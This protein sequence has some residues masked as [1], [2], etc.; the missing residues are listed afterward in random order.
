MA[1]MTAMRWR[2]LCLVSLAANLGLA[3]GWWLSLRHARPPGPVETVLSDTNASPQIR[4]NVVFRRQF[5]SWSELESPDY[6]KYIAN[7]RDIACP[8]QTIRDIIIADVNA[9]YARR[10]AAE[11]ITPEQQWWRAEPDP[12]VQATAQAKLRELDAERRALLTSLLGPAWEIGDQLSLPRPSRPGVTLDGPVLG[13]L[14]A[15]VK[16]TVQEITSQSQDRLQA[17]WETRQQEGRPLDPADLAKFRQQ[18]REELARVLTPP[19]LEEFLLRFSESAAH[20]REEL[21]HLQYFNATPEEFR[22]LFRARDAVDLQLAL[23]GE[24]TDPATMLRRT[25]LE[26]QRDQAM[27]LALGK[28]RF[29]EFQKLQDPTYR[30]AFAEAQQAGRPEAADTLHEISLATAAEQQ[31]I[32]DDAT[33]TDMQKAIEL[34]RLELEQLRANAEALGQA[35]P[36][37]PPPPPPRLRAHTFHERETLVELSLRYDVSISAIMAANPDLDF[38][39]LQPGVTIKIPEPA[40][41]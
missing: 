14:S 11:I 22:A 6:A 33:L 8:E 29:E 38:N 37:E 12:V 23:L 24:A 3:V 10:R 5:F 7:L 16:Q 17:Y 26:Q 1:L 31:H 15:E 27:Q 20:L 13:L 41:R 19:Q 39:K 32:R 28:T 30:E 18:T 21:A 9:L 4:T 25:E 40:R 2:V 35:L 34:K 36:P